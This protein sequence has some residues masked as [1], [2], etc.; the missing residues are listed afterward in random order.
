MELITPKPGVHTRTETDFMM[1]KL[2]QGV[3]EATSLS[4]FISCITCRLGRTHTDKP[5]NTS[6]ETH[7]LL[8]W[9][10]SLYCK[11]QCGHLL[12]TKQTTAIANANYDYN[13]NSHCK[14]RGHLKTLTL[15]PLGPEVPGIPLSPGIPCRPAAPTSPRLPEGPALP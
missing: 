15:S 8:K 13:F 6:Q 5:G 2:E 1:E 3:M 14:V 9:T 11:S 10:L 4:Q 7:I 12:N